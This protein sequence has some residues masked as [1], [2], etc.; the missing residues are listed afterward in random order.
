MRPVSPSLLQ[1]ESPGVILHRIE[2]SSGSALRLP[3]DLA[4]SVDVAGYES[5]SWRG[6]AHGDHTGND[7]AN[8]FAQLRDVWQTISCATCD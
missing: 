3:D 8:R 4:A 1:R 2:M 6:H 7:L 5:A